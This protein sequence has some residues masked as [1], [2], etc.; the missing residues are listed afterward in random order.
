MGHGLDT[1]IPRK[2]RDKY[3][4]SEMSRTTKGHTR[5]PVYQMGAG[6]KVNEV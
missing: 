6:S 1:T 3:L 4:F 2:A 5:L